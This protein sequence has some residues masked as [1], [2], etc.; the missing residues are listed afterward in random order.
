MA[1]M[2]TLLFEFGVDHPVAQG[3]AFGV[4]LVDPAHQ[5]QVVLTDPFGTIIEATAIKA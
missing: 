5:V 3:G 1:D 2:V 4:D